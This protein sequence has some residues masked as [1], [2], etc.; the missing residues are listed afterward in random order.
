M[1]RLLTRLLTA[2]SSIWNWLGLLKIQVKQEGLY[3][4]DIR[5]DNCDIRVVFND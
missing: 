2:I 1:A 4:Q 3:S 5:F